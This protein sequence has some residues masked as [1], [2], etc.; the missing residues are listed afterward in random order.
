[1]SSTLLSQLEQQI[2]WLRESAI[3]RPSGVSDAGAVHAWIE[4]ATAGEPKFSFLYSEITG[5]FMTL[6]AQL[7]QGLGK[8]AAAAGLSVGNDWPRRAARAAEWIVSC[9]MHP[10]GAV[11]TR[12][13]L[14]VA[15]GDRF[16]FEGGLTGF[17]DSAMVG[18]GL[19]L[20]H[21]IT[22]DER[23]LA[24]AR[25]ICGFM[26]HAFESRDH[27]QRWAWY[28]LKKGAAL[29]PESRWSMHFGPYE[30][31]LYSLP[32]EKLDRV[33]GG[34][35]LGH[36]GSPLPRGRARLQ[37]ANRKTRRPGVDIAACVGAFSD[38]A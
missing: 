38:R 25:K 24:A 4:Q 23:W 16:S 6:C 21:Q 28:D 2:N 32:K 37:F 36:P 26:R 13:H 33:E 30:T 27:S 18:Y 31:N 15:T 7:S 1:M 29:E 20:T 19:L 35:V 8:A 14:G 11:L 12:K 5:Y 9:A 34:D 22:G 10:S 3:Q 17:F